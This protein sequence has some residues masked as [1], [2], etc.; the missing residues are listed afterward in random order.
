MALPVKVG[1]EL[2]DVPFPEMVEKMALAIAN[3]QIALD[4]NS[5]KTAQ[6]LATTM[7]PEGTVAVA[8]KE[9]VDEDGN[10]TNS[11]IEY[12]D[13]EMPL[14]VFGINP[15]FYQFTDTIIEVKMAITMKIEKS[16]SFSFGS[17]FSFENKTKFSASFKTGG[18]LGLLAGKGSSSVENT[19]TVAYSSTFNAKYSSK[20]SF[21]Q[22]GTSLLR[23]TL[24]PVPPPDRAVPKIIV[25]E[26]SSTPTPG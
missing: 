5:I 7:I 18:L 20:Y 9:T 1:Q 24:R 2:L 19:T 21:Q 3:G 23:T 16:T 14:L 13:K 6:A 17:K 10:V 12:N 22:E 15:T 11:E 26:S 25:K 8:I 4:L